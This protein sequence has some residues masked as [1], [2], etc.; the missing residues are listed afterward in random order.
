M[1]EDV[2]KRQR[3]NLEEL[4]WAFDV[5]DGQ[6]EV[7]FEFE[8]NDHRHESW[9]MNNDELDHKYGVLLVL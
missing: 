9:Y 8:F 3:L 1:R 2:R 4:G 6:A 5:F 7:E